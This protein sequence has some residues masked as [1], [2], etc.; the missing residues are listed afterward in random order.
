MNPE[1]NNWLL[2]K[3]EQSV[4]SASEFCWSLPPEHPLEDGKMAS[5]GAAHHPARLRGHPS[6]FEEGR[7]VSRD[8]CE[9][10]FPRLIEAGSLRRQAGRWAM[11]EKFDGRYFESDIASISPAAPH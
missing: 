9:M 2:Q 4:M 8:E 6:S 11:P 5:A 1:D 3:P 10:N 7:N